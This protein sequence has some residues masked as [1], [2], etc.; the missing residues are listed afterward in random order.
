MKWITSGLDWIGLGL[1]WRDETLHVRRAIRRPRLIIT[2][3][4]LTRVRG[5][6]K[7]EGEGGGEEEAR[8][9]SG[10]LWLD[11]KRRGFTR[12]KMMYREKDTSSLK[13]K[14][15]GR[16]EKGDR[17]GR[18]ETGRERERKEGCV[19]GGELEDVV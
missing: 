15:K 18:E 11:R 10:R 1:D 12:S 6:G 8:G 3:Q 7:E 16:K 2:L 4:H 5:G 13:G 14:R 19:E 9:G 17:G